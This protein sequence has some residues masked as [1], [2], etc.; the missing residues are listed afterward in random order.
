[1]P[2]IELTQSPKEGD[3]AVLKDNF[4]Y[5]WG[6]SIMFTTF[7][8]HDEEIAANNDKNYYILTKQ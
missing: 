5:G 7:S 1:M 3:L 8:K 2:T 4:D 6:H